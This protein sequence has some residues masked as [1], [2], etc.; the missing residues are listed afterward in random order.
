MAS[1]RAVSSVA[2]L[3]QAVAFLPFGHWSPLLFMKSSAVPT[4]ACAVSTPA[5]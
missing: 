1:R 5:Q 2:P 3:S 4:Q